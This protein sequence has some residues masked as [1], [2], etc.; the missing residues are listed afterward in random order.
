MP[1]WLQW[2]KLE[3]LRVGTES[4]SLLMRRTDT[5]VAVEVLKKPHSVTVEVRE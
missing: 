3:D 4:I 1:T 2:L 5:A